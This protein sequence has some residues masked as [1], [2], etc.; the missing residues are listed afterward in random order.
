MLQWWWWALGKGVGTGQGRQD[1]LYSSSFF[2]TLGHYNG[3][4]TVLWVTEVGMGFVWDMMDR[5]ILFVPSGTWCGWDIACDGDLLFFYWCVDI[6]N[7]MAWVHIG[8]GDSALL[9]PLPCVA[10]AGWVTGRLGYCTTDSNL[11]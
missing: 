4:Q 11:A 8:M 6:C 1:R 9:R 5:T 7:G 10:W 2:N 3:H